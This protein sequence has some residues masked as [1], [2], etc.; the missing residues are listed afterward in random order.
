MKE[1]CI[2]DVGEVEIWLNG[3]LAGS[4]EVK[5]VYNLCFSLV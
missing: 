4:M 5:R 2:W 1:Y 3:E